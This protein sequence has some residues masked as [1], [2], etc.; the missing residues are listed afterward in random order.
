MDESSDELS[1]SGLTA[2]VLFY[3]HCKDRGVGDCEVNSSRIQLRRCKIRSSRK[4]NYLNVWP[5]GKDLRG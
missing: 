5:A 2:I 3:L 4:S 1:Q